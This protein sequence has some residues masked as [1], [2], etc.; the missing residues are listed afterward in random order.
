MVS[1]GLMKRELRAGV[2]RP[3]QEQ[4]PIATD[5]TVGMPLWGMGREAQDLPVLFPEA[6]VSDGMFA[7]A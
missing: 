4:L 2:L 3:R 7:T 6:P 5:D 1:T